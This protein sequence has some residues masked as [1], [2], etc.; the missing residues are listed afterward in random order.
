MNLSITLVIIIITVLVSVMAFQNKE[1]LA[2]S[3]FNA[4]LVK[5]SKEWHRVITHAFVHSGFMHLAV[6]M[7]V[8][9]MFGQMVE[10]AFMR[11]SEAIGRVAYAALYLGGI[12]FAT[13]P[14]YQKHQNNWNYNAV[15]ASGAV[16]AVLFSA[17]YFAPTMDLYLMFIPIPIPAIIF[18]I[19]YLALEWYMDKKS[20][21]NIAHDAHFWGAAFGVAFSLLMFPSQFGP[22][23]NAILRRF[24]P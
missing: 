15:G 4:Y 6:N 2:K 5:H 21:D 17:I 14:A 22:F 13:L 3:M 8:L 10:R 9:Y 24:I 12:V 1:M 18:G 7:Y 19:G 20:N 11:E 23:I 16:A